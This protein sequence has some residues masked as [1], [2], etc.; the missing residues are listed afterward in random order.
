MKRKSRLGVDLVAL[1]LALGLALTVVMIIVATTV[2]ILHNQPHQPE[3]QLSENST[4]V[5]IAA[6]GGIVGVLGGYIGHRLNDR[7]SRD[8]DTDEEL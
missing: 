8:T 4:Q 5:L 3:I 2:Q 7:R 1:V 6:I